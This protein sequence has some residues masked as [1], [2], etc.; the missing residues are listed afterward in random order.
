MRAI[1]LDYILVI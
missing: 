1:V